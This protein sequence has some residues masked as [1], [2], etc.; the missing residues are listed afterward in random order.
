MAGLINRRGL[1]TQP[2]P[3]STASRQNRQNRLHQRGG[4]GP[5]RGGGGGSGGAGG[6][7]PNTGLYHGRAGRAFANQQPEQFFRSAVSRV[8]GLNY[9]G[10]PIDEFSQSFVSKLLDDYLAKQAGAQ[11][12]DPV[13]YLRQTYGAGFLGRKGRNFNPGTLGTEGGA[14]DAAYQNYYSNTQPLDYLYGQEGGGGANAEFDRYLQEQFNPG[15]VAET[16]VARAAD[17]T[18]NVNDLIAG[19]DLMG[20]ARRRF[21]ARPNAQRQPGP[22]NLGSRWSWWE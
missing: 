21:L 2:Q 10:T 11:R 3:V 8:G 6:R 5:N 22:V 18:A 13:K 4:G 17:P 20:E 14:L 12:L 7:L 19:R 9:S 15:V 16:T 1:G